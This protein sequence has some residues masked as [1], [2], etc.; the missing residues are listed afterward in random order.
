MKKGSLEELT[1]TELCDL[2]AEY[3]LKLLESIERKADGIT[4][5]DQKNQVEVVQELIRRKRAGGET[6]SY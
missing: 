2:L 1:L 3:T 5:R 6:T 4:L